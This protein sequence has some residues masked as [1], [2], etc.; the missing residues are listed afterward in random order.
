G[1]LYYTPYSSNSIALYDGSSEWNVFSFTELS[2]NVPTSAIDKNYDVFASWDTTTGGVALSLTAWTDDTTR[3]T[4]LSR[5]S[6][7][8]YLQSGTLTRRYLGT[9]RGST[10]GK[11]A[12]T[13]A[14]RFVWNMDNRVI[15]TSNTNEGVTSWTATNLSWAP[16]H[17]GNA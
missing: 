10:T 17:G 14:K 9:I 13:N 4:A 15:R 8:V 5:D 7:G 11:V 12:D 2:T 6:S 3:A 16:L 1:T